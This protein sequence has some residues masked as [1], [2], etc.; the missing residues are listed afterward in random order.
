MTSQ[1]NPEDFVPQAAI[2]NSFALG[3]DFFTPEGGLLTI[4]GED[5]TGWQV[6]LV[7]LMP[8]RSVR[9]FPP[10]G[11]TLSECPRGCLSPDGRLLAITERSTALWDLRTGE[12]L[13]VLSDEW[14]GK[15]FAFSPDSRLFA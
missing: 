15:R 9:S 14:G 4:V 10:P 12:R 7:E 8:A 13:H 3:D 5:S 11:E 6:S 2:N 1:E